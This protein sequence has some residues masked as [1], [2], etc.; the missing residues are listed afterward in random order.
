MVQVG[1]LQW[2]ASS[3]YVMFGGSLWKDLHVGCT[4]RLGDLWVNKAQTMYKERPE[5]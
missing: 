3:V 4:P 2:E 5:S 1:T